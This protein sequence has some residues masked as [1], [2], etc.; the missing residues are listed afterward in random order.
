MVVTP[1]SSSA[2]RAVGYDGYV[3]TVE[4]HNGGVYDHPGVP[5]EVYAEL[6]AADSKGTY[7][8]QYIRGRYR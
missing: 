3:L 4:F 2:I 8:S 1:V 5:Y 7:Y 6:M